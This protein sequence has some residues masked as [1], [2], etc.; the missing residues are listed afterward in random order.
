MLQ[1]NQ[2]K[3]RQRDE[4]EKEIKGKPLIASVIIFLGLGILVLAIGASVSIGA[5][6]I[7][8]STVWQSLFQFDAASTSHQIIQRLR[9]P[10]AIGAALIG[11]SLAVSGAIMQGMTRNP[12]ASPS[13]MGISAGS[14]FMMAIVLAFFPHSSSFSL[15][16]FA[17][18]GAGLGACLVFGIG[19]LSRGG[20]TP[21]KLALAG[22]AISLL[23]D[24]ISTA[25]GIHFDV[26][27]DLSFW[28]AGGLA[29]VQKES[30]SLLLPFTAIGL[31]LAL[32]IARSV[33]VLSLGQEVAKGLGQN[34]TAVRVIGT[35]TVLL[36]TGA[37]VSVA[38]L[39]G[40]I[41]LVIPHV[42]RFLVGLD[43]RFIIPCSAVL[44]ALLLV[45]ADIAARMINQPFETPVGAVTALI[46]VPFFLYLARN[47]GRGL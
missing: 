43:Y 16:I 30:I 9:L 32:L 4:E 5:A 10:R 1:R 7:N 6:D 46:G 40:F 3:E 29:G 15:T 27:K 24:S 19:S 17:M 31:I 12:L 20:L 28:Y 14:L 42:T 44:G 8:L 41:G 25:I 36:L 47:E 2:T 13:I 21:V 18:V 37:A 23:L 35:I 22:T 26:G 34:T 33:T 11:A 39:I 38:G 45:I